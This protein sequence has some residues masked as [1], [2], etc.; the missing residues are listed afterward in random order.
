MSD[1]IVLAVIS[2][3]VSGAASGWLT[4]NLHIRSMRSSRADSGS[5]VASGRGNVVAAGGGQAAS[6]KRGSISQTTIAS[7]RPAQ[8]TATVERSPDPG[9]P[10]QVLVVRNIGDRPV[11]DLLVR[12]T[13]DGGGFLTQPNWANFPAHLS[14]GQRVAVLCV[15]SGAGYVTFQVSY[16]DGGSAT[17]PILLQATHA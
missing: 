4:S 5:Q 9:L 6:A 12:P 10:R 15:T 16:V 7:E 3:L 8:L 11:D 1:T 17:G 13:H 14:G 2:G